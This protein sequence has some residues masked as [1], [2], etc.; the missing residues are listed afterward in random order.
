M[1]DQATRDAPRT[2]TCGLDAAVAVIG[3]K[4]KPLI[5]WALQPRTRRFGQ[6]RRDIP[7]ISEKMLIQQLKELA[8]DQVVHREVYREVPPRV[9]YSL[10][11]FGRSL[12]TALVPL[13]DWGE[14]HMERVGAIYR[15]NHAHAES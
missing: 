2:Y 10:T 5:L 11:D 6:L 13:N 8:A 7:G 14:H 15:C 1:R 3:G 4:W 9:E 12:H